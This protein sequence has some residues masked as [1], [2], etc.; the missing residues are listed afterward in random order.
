MASPLRKIDIGALLLRLCVGGLMMF[1]GVD[2]LLNGIDGM[3]PLLSKKGLPSFLQYGVY[4]GELLAPLLLILGVLPRTA[5]LLITSTMLIAVYALH[6]GDL[7]SVGKHGEYALEVQVFYIVG[8]VVIAII[9][10][11]RVAIPVGRHLAKF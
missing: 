8:A 11:G 4:A 1:H 10:P 2:K 3:G 9:G 6:M 7:L 5:A